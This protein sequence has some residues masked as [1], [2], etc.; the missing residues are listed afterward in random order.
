MN[1][2]LI[3]K[4][5]FP[6]GGDAVVTL[7]TGRLLAEHGHTVNYWGMRHAANPPYPHE[8]L[9]VDEVDYH[10]RPT[11]VSALRQSLN[12]LYSFEA[13]RKVEQMI[14]ATRPDLVH[15][16]NFAHQISPSILHVFRKHR[17]PVVM[18]LHDYKPVCPVYTLFTRG[19]T[20]QQC[21]HGRFYRCAVNRCTQGSLAK[22]LLNT[23]EMYL[24]HR[25]LRIYDLIQ[26]FLAPSRF[27]EKTVKDMG[28]KGKV[29][30]L[31]NFVD[32]SRFPLGPQRRE[33]A[34]V[35]A[36]RLSPE[37]GLRTLVAAAAGLE[38]VV[39]I[40]GEGPQKSELSQLAHAAGARQVRF[41][42]YLRGAELQREI[43]DSL[44]VVQPSEWF[45]NNP[46]SVLEAFALGT[47]VISTDMGG[48]PELV[49][50]GRTGL[51]FT[52][53][54]AVDLRRQLI[55]VLE[56]PEQAASWGRTA[57]N[58]VEN[59]FNPENH[60]RALLNFYQQAAEART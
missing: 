7:N 14:E 1:V 13:R 55:R 2:L 28:F 60:Y 19:Q 48:L 21:H 34:V 35:Y 59:E 45:E 20:C 9:F 16:H 52:P 24:H 27:L 41:L 47:P 38:I 43:Q 36:G 54:D 32:T 30:W 31:P 29:A 56:A 17:L 42:G 49:R 8:K 40:I 25:L 46:L 50:P 22:S 11:P 37:K 15:V 12:V 58:F 26:V 57:R 44:A 10:A 39:K 33:R 3:N 53:G 4:F 51:T 6:K 18:T 23:A 5:L